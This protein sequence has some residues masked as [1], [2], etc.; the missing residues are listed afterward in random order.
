[1][2]T[3]SWRGR[4]RSGEN[5]TGEL[6][7]ENPNEVAQRLIGQGVTPTRIAIAEEAASKASPISRKHKIRP[8]DLLMLCR[9]MY[10]ITRSSLPLIRGLKGLSASSQNP[11][12][13][14]L[15]DL[16]VTRLES[17]LSLS[18][19]LSASSEAFDKLFI[20]LVSVGEATGR[21]DQIFAQ[22]G[23]HI[24]RDIETRKQIKQAVRYP[25]FVVA[26]LVLAFVLINI[27]VIPA[28]AEI[29]ERMDAE[30]PAITVLLMATSSFC[31]DYWQIGI[32]AGLD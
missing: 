4:S 7:G 8:A 15:L 6:T 11:E 25:S 18:Q 5:L 21:L 17:G 26:T 20:G 28:F 14:R 3:Y 27:F 2:N 22:L 30:L 16:L 19:A 31:V 29:F 10:T 1:M 23:K 12:L 24:A 32:G 9:Q 13:R